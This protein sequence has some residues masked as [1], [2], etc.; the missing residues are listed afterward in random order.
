MRRE[1]KPVLGSRLAPLTLR[2]PWWPRG[3]AERRGS[4]GP[5]ELGADTP[6]VAGWD[7]KFFCGE[8]IVSLHWWGFR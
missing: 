3:L 4:L 6:R 7:P 2:S 8:Q 1:R 5:A